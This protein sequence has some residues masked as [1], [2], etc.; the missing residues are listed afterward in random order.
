[1]TEA[2]PL[3]ENSLPEDLLPALP[4]PGTPDPA[5]TRRRTWLLTAMV[6]LVVLIYLCGWSTY[7]AV[8]VHQRYRQLEPGAAAERGAVSFRLLSLRQTLQVPTEDEPLAAAPGATFVVAVVELTQQQVEPVQGCEQLALLGQDGRRWD[9]TFAS[10]AKLD[11]DFCQ[12]DDVALGRPYR[13]SILFTVPSSHVDGLVGV[14]VLDEA[15]ATRTPVLR[16]VS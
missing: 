8:H 13:Y 14:A 11:P 9:S 7:A 16:P 15:T 6:G 1:M 5:A 4:P 2:P 12:F 3:P 10:E